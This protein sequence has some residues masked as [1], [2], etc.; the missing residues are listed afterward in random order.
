MKINIAFHWLAMALASV[1]CCTALAADIPSTQ[2]DKASFADVLARLKGDV[3][4]ATSVQDKAGQHLLVL[5]KQ[6]GP[7]TVEED[8]SRQDR[9]DLRAA[10][11]LKTGSSWT[12]EWVMTDFVDCPGLDHSAAF[13]TQY[14]AFTDL[15]GDGLAEV[16][17]PY[18]MFCGGGVDSSSI[19][20]ILRD[21]Q[22]KFAIRGQTRVVLEGQEPFGGE[23][24]EDPSL[25]LP[26]NA[27]IKARLNAV[28]G[29]IY[30]E[31][32]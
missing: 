18:R 3:I 15:D 12:Q 8:L 19:K 28:W 11:Y 25:L 4:L 22:E 9:T 23:K 13:Y 5:S 24:N 1:T 14:V 30:V 26:E 27:A 6:S 17:V 20:V 31:H 16:T 29:R 21:G 2:V 7:S 32:L 10:W